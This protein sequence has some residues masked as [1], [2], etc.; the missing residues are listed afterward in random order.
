MAYESV[1][2]IASNSLALR[3]A[4]SGKANRREGFSQTLPLLSRN[5]MLDAN[6]KS[7]LKAYFERLVHPVELVA[8]LD[9]GAKS[10]EVLA[11]LEDIASLSDKIALKRDGTDGRKPSFAIRR[12]GEEA[13][14][15]FAGLPMGHEFNSLILA[16]LQVGG[17]A[18]KESADVLAQV[19][20]L[21]GK[22]RFETYFSLSCQN[23][24][25]IVQALNLIAALN[26]NV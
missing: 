4:L 15:H 17:H 3:Y 2:V 5:A 8:S 11:L 18:P 20:S 25:D 21:K 26:A 23:C 1:E 22:F 14:V 24:P 13:R 6:I 12:A 7:Q 9:D 10:A 16:L 19:K